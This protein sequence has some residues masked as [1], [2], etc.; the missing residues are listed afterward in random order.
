MAAT[1]STSRTDFIKI[2]EMATV[3]GVSQRTLRYYEELKLITP[4]RSDGGVRLYSSADVAKVR[5]IMRRVQNGESLGSLILAQS[6]RKPSMLAEAARLRS[7]ARR[8]KGEKGGEEV[9]TG[10]RFKIGDIAKRLQTTVRTLRYYE[11]EGIVAASRSEG[12]TRLYSLDDYHAL[13]TTLTLTRLG[14]GLETV[15]R[16]ACARKSCRT[17]DEASSLMSDILGE[18]REIVAEKLALYAELEKDIDR[19]DLLVQ[20]CRGCRNTPTRKGCPACPMERNLDR[21]K[22]ARL[23]WDRSKDHARMRRGLKHLA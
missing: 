20:Q 10:R 18:V 13:Q 1:R 4:H 11:E 9:R 16:L 12:G 14:L 15:K 23:I 6:Q 5:E 3:C 22:L 19:A 7:A 2:G 17:G 8:P 21:S